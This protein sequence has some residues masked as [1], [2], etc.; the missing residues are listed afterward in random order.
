MKSANNLVKFVSAGV[1]AAGV[2]IMPMT[3]PASAQVVVPGAE[4]EGIYEDNND[5]NWGLW[6]LVGL[7]GLFGLVGGGKRKE[8]RT[9]E[10]QDNV[11]AYR[12]PNKR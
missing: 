5:G 8:T 10:A 11:T 1:L 9:P 12:D 6:G 2:S 7:V 4:R 3:I